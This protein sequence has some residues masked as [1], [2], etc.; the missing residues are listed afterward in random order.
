MIWQGRD[1]VRWVGLLCVSAAAWGQNA[2]GVA[3]FE[4]NIRP[5]LAA[6]CYACHSAKAATPMGGLRLDS[7][8]GMLRGGGSGAPAVVP[9]KPEESLLVNA[10]R[11]TG[12]LKMP[13]GKKLE[14]AEI[15]AV[16]EWI[17]M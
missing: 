3:Y 11:Q 14:A 9:G 1:M 7:K 6:N 10:L 2:D 16:V 8:S 5:L 17:R 15:D 12:N 4:K 13:P